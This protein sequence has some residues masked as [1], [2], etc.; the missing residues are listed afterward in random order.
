MLGI[1]SRFHT[2][3]LALPLRN[4]I[5]EYFAPYKRELKKE[6]AKEAP[7]PEYDVLYEPISHE[8]SLSDAKNIEEHSWATTE[9]LTEGIEEYALEDEVIA[10]YEPEPSPE[11]NDVDS[12]IAKALIC[13][14][15]N[16]KQGFTALSHDIGVLPD[17]LC[18]AINDRLY[19]TLGDIAVEQ[20]D[21][22]YSIV[23]DYME[24]INEWLKTVKK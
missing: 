7:K 1:R 23:V 9:L 20:G 11:K 14:I 4:A 15:N 2:P 21:D 12:E 18:E 17:A 19:D 8:L 22:G 3:N 10:P 13:L 5:E 6:Q 16:D 24:E